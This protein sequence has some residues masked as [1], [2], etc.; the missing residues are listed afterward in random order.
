MGVKVR[1]FVHEQGYNVSVTDYLNGFQYSNEKLQFFPHKEG[2][3]QFYREGLE[4]G[5]TNQGNNGAPLQEGFSYVYQ[6]KDHLGNNRL[7]F[8]LN[9]EGTLSILSEDHYYPFGM[10]HPYNNDKR[11]WTF[12]RIENIPTPFVRQ[13]PNSGYQYKFNVKELQDELGLNIYDYGARNYDPALGRWMNMDPLEEIAPD[14]TSY[15]FVSNN[16]IN[17]IDPNGLTDYEINSKGEVV[18]T[19]E[20]KKADNFYMVDNDGNRIEGKSITFDYGTVESHRSQ[21]GTY[22]KRNADGTRSEVVTTIDIFKVRGD[23][24]GT[25]LFEFFADNTSVEWSQAKT[26]IEGDK[27]LNFLTT[28]HIEYTEPGIAALINGQL[29]GGYTIRELNH[30]HPGGTAVP[31]GIPGLTGSS[32]DV[33]FAKAVTEW[34]KKAY[35]NRSSSPTYNI[36]ITGKGYIPYSKDSKKEDYG[37]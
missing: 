29:S 35:P 37:Y 7:N 23:D 33:S 36:Y 32:G 8:T 34:Y 2:Y 1:K 12:I 5:N 25:Q 17:R 14:K 4:N 6:F 9:R 20:N 3:V 26:G 10:K 30:N 24:N 11:D 22:Q 18:K 16:P 28:G 27:G 21:S 13:V 15:H 19:I 31:S